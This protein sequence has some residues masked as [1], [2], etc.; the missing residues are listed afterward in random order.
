MS[1]TRKV[2]FNRKQIEA[3]K[4]SANKEYIVA[5]RG[6]GKSEGIDA[7]RL[8][9]N[10]LSMPRSAGALLSPTYGK[11]LRNTLPAVCSALDRLGYKRNLHYFVGHK[12][13][14]SMNFAKPLVEPFD[15]DYVMHWFDGS[16]NNLLSFDRPM[17]AN[18]MNLDYVMGFEAK[19]LDYDK[20]KNEVFPANRGN[21][22]KFGDC[23]WH[24]GHVFT[25]DMPTNKAGQWIFDKENDM[26]KELIETIMLLNSEIQRLKSLKLN[27]QRLAKLQKDLAKLRSNATFYAEYNV[28]DN[29]EI[30]GEK[31]IRDMKRDLSP[32]IFQTAILNKRI[33]KIEGGFYSALNEKIHYY[34]S[35]DNSFLERLDYDIKKA[36]EADCRKDGD[37]DH[38]RPLCIALDYNANIN[39]LVCGQADAKLMR[40]LTSFFVK[41]D[42]RTGELIEKFHDYYQI[43]NNRDIVFYYTHTALQGAYAIS[44]NT[45]ADFVIQ[46]LQ[47]KGWNVYPVYMGQALNHVVKH[48]YINDGLKGTQYLF[49]QFNQDNNEELLIAMEQTGTKVGAEGFKKDKSGEKN[50]ES[51]ENQLQ[52]RTDGTDAWD[53]LYLGCV[54]HP[55]ETIINSSVGNMW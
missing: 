1:E 32:F 39:W 18:S 41:G 27:P 31:F 34:T 29:I 49:P 8:V 47:H 6:F 26:D 40:T 28:F 9:R 43:R 44:G 55:V 48:R 51:Q 22:D 33:R 5:S 13:P 10:V 3:M 23:P 37:M 14:K 53:D 17:S 4:V 36:V 54:F 11:L 24:H 30:L 45:F 46:Q 2:Y 12:A 42:K 35:Y 50:P 52:Y 20:I 25:T 38:E 7:P 21:I 16:I 15:Y 19:F